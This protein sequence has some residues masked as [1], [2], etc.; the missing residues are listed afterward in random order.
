MLMSQHVSLPPLA[1]YFEFSLRFI[2]S[3]AK[4]KKKIHY[5]L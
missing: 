5:A 2:A 3:T 4:V 1:D